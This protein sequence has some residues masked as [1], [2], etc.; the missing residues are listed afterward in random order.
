M[1]KPVNLFLGI[2]H[3]LAQFENSIED[4]LS[5]SAPNDDALGQQVRFFLDDRQVSDMELPLQRAV[6]E[7]RVI[8]THGAKSAAA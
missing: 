7:N 6:A 5:A 3:Y 2:L 1:I 4:N 8:S